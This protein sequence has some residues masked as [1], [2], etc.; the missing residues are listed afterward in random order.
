MCSLL[1]SKL[2]VLCFSF[3]RLRT[4]NRKMQRV[5]LIL[6]DNNE[7]AEDEYRVVFSSDEITMYDKENKV[8]N[9]NPE[10]IYEREFSENP[11]YLW[12]R[13][14]KFLNLSCNEEGYFSLRNSFP[15]KTLFATL[16]Q[17]IRKKS[18]IATPWSKPSTPTYFLLRV[19]EEIE[20]L[21]LVGEEIVEKGW[22]FCHEQIF[23][24][25][26]LF[27]NLNDFRRK[28]IYENRMLEFDIQHRIRFP[29]FEDLKDTKK[30]EVTLPISPL[31]EKEQL[32]ILCV[33]LKVLSSG[34]KII[35][36]QQKKNCPFSACSQ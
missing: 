16:D 26:E 33:Y 32:K 8:G 5:L 14:T 1:V 19:S 11:K 18:S 15:E 3:T 4:E 34:K 6:K 29:A 25:C 7:F 27:E 31:S 30:K 13:V 20:F 24:F 17:E 12:K 35:A 21:L 28:A 22:V 36:H 23:L 9:L 10:I 2:Q